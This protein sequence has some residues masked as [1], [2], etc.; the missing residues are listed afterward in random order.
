MIRT[1]KTPAILDGLA[2]LGL[3]LLMVGVLALWT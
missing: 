1:L 3:F 2:T